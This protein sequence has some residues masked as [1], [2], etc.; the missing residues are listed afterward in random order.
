MTVNVL[1]G[2]FLTGEITATIPVISL[3]WTEVLNGAGS[4]DVTVT[5]DVVR[6]HGLREKTHGVRSFLA[7]EVDGRIKQAGPIWSRTW[8]WEKGQ[9]SLGA[10]GFWSWLDRRVIYPAD[11]AA[12]FQSD[13]FSVSGKSLGGIAR[14]LVERATGSALSA[15][16]VVL[17]VDEAGDHTESF[18]LWSV[19]FHGEQLR[20]IT[21]RAIDAPDIRFA[22]RRRADD[23]RF[24][25]WVME[26]GT[27]AMPSLSQGGPDWVFDASAP[28]SPVLGISPDEDATQMATQVWVTGN[29]MEEDILMAHDASGELP[30]LGWPVIDAS[31]SHQT[32]EQQATLDGHAASLLARLS[33]PVEVFKVSVRA[34]AANEVQAG[35]YARLVTKADPYAGD[36]DRTM[37]VKQ[38]SG[39]LSDTVTLEMFP[40]AALL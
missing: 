36:M 12:P 5:S 25:E 1:V 7:V 30:A 11:A 23:R 4:I 16:P 32:V 8:D 26:V 14:A 29:G 9:L 15:V 40:M 24:L 27:E 37:R 35:D 10:A 31:A 34:K 21:Q 28:K 38:V 33:R 20:Q 22:P 13:V 2:E 6:E 3:R 19:P 18:P 17:P 39:D